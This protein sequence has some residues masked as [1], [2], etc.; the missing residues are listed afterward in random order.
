MRFVLEPEQKSSETRRRLPAYPSSQG[1]DRGFLPDLRRNAGNQ[2]IQALLRS[3]LLQPMLTAGS[4]DDPAEREAEAVATHI[5]GPPTGRGM[6]VVPSQERSFLQRHPLRQDKS[7][8]VPGIVE[9]VLH[10]AGRPLDA[11]TRA[12][13]E[14]RLGQDLSLIRVHTDQAAADSAHS[15]H[16]LA[17]TSGRDIAFAQGRYSPDT[18][19]GK[20]LLAHELTHTV[21]QASRSSSVV[22]RTPDLG[23]LNVNV[24]H[25]GTNVP[26]SGANVHIDQKLVSSSKSV[27]LV[28]DRDGNTPYIQLEEGNYTITVTYKCCQQVQDVHIIGNSDQMTFFPLGRCECGISSADQSDGGAVASAVSADG[29]ASMVG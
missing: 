4:M 7:S 29:G 3:G 22:Q 13:F 28:T 5:A 11:A 6:S 17:Y 25:Q 10:S 15:I 19:E 26:I 12:F 23:G 27:D 24:F 18:E 9:Q 8:S 2:A 1:R 16:A 20:R 21:Q 14:P